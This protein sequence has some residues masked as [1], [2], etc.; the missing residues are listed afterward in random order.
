VDKKL[1]SVGEAAALLGVSRTTFNKIRKENGLSEVMV[2]KRARFYRD[3]LLA[4]LVRTQKDSVPPRV[5]TTSK[6][7]IPPISKDTI[8]NI[9]SN[10][11]VGQIEIEKNVFDLTALKQIDPYGAL[12]LLCTL[13]DRA[14]RDDKIRLIVNDGVACQSLK[15]AHFFYQVENQC[16][17]K[18]TWDTSVL[19][20]QTFE[21]T[22]LLMPIR[23]I[24]AKGAERTIAEALIVLLRKQGFHDALG[25][26]IAHI[27]G[28]LADNAMTHSAQLLSERICY[29]SAQRFLYE[30]KDS[31]IVG[32]ADPGKGIPNTLK[33][34]S[35]YSHL[36]NQ[37]AFLQAF[38][39][40]VTSWEA[41]RGKGLADVLAIALGNNSYLRADSGPIGLL[42]DFHERDRPLI[43]F[44]TPLADVTGT[45]FGLVLIDNH[46][47]S[48]TRTEVD[49][50]LIAKVSELS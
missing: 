46:F 44:N 20:G 17:S 33:S 6:K 42:M 41:K 31:I 43:S 2:G 3:E 39:P 23:A 49:E 22:N 35:R 32:L 48:C 29:V 12:S 25:R 37:E 11:T 50:V 30:Q 27:I 40:Y 16:G 7:T 4:G 14:R 15:A 28:E 8:L 34:S 1:L 45:R 24:R 9:F 13:V 21:D 47:E 19:A 18:V 26:G 10:Q 5:S 36:T 38:R